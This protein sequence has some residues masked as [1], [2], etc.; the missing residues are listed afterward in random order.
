MPYLPNA[1]KF[2]ISMFTCLLLSLGRNS[3][4][5]FGTP[6]KAVALSRVWTCVLGL[7]S[8]VGGCQVTSERHPGLHGSGAS[9]VP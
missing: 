3:L 5:L 8:V 6:L 4:L 7:G 2:D 1:L 9:A